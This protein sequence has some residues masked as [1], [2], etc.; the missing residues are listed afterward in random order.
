MKA[1]ISGPEQFL[2]IPQSL[3]TSHNL[4]WQKNAKIINEKPPVHEQKGAFDEGWLQLQTWNQ[5]Q[6][7]QLNTSTFHWKPLIFRTIPST[8]PAAGVSAT[9]H[10][11]TIITPK[12]VEHLKIYYNQI[13]LGMQYRTCA[14]AVS[15]QSPENN[16]NI[17]ITKQKCLVSPHLW[18]LQ[19]ACFW[20]HDNVSHVSLLIKEFGPWATQAKCGHLDSGVLLR[21]QCMMS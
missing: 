10:R 20:I 2:L 18:N 16:L 3:L 19:T 21:L 9:A 6:L 15:R 4:F 5:N 7:L 17:L 12:A 11:F 1:A 14:C 8:T 13:T